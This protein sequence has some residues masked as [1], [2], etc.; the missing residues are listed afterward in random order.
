MK[1]KEDP[2]QRIPGRTDSPQQMVAHLT[3]HLEKGGH[4]PLKF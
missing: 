3:Q 2:E 1:L 4:S